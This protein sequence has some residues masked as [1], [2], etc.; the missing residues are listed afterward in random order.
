MNK[1]AKRIDPSHKAAISRIKGYI[2]DSNGRGFDGDSYPFKEAVRQL[3]K[4]GVIITY[5]REKCSYFLG[6]PA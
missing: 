6:G 5:D 2:M 4:K 1:D 3:R